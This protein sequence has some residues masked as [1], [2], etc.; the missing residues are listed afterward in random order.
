MLILIN[1]AHLDDPNIRTDR[2]LSPQH[3]QLYTRYPVLRS[4][5]L[6]QLDMSIS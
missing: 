3:A 6:E 4:T 5:H 2:V 1:F